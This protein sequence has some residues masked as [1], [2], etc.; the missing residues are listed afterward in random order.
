MVLI[1][2]KYGYFNFK[3]FPIW[4]KMLLHIVWTWFVITSANGSV[5]MICVSTKV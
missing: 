5:I 4:R 2:V 1:I 3:L